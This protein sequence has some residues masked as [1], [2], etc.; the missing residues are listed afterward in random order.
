MDGSYTQSDSEL[1]KTNIA[2]STRQLTR[3]AIMLTPTDRA[4]VQLVRSLAVSCIALLVDFGLLMT[5]KEIFLVNYMVAAVVGFLAG[6]LVN[7]QLSIKWVFAS[8]KLASQSAEFTIFVII[9][10]IGLILNIAIIAGM[11]ELIKVDYRVAKGVSTAA[12]F[13]WN[14]AARKKILY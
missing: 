2:Y 12:V 3:E 4:S 7:Y 5:L 1:A 13:F 8:R 9:C 10:I 14:F 11:V 6:V